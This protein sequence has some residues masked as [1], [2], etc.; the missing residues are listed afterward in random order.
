MINPKRLSLP[1]SRESVLALKAGDLVELSGEI[2]MTAGIPTHQRII[3]FLRAGKPLPIDMTGGS[4]LHLGGLNQEGPDGK[5]SVAY[6]NPTTS[7]R[8]NRFMPEIIRGLDLRVTG[9]K[10]GLDAECAAAMRDT[11]CVYLSFLGGGCTLLSNALREVT[12]VAWTD[13]LI[14]YRLVRVRVEGLG[15]ATVGIDAHGNSLYGD[16]EA[17][18]HERLPSILKNLEDDRAVAA[19][20]LA[21]R[22]E[23]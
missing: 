7:T 5:A 22:Q 6:L 16:G 11:G 3:D 14:H 13:L 21:E 8:F 20:L 10:G 1:L 15:P 18:A 12:T 2:V 4:L 23:K 9:G 17:R 19:S